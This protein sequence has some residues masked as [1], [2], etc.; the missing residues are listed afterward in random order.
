MWLGL[1]LVRPTL[2]LSRLRRADMSRWFCISILAA[3]LLSGTS[4]AT[5]QSGP[6]AKQLAA[7]GHTTFVQV[8]GGDEAKLGEAIQS[9]EQA[10][11]LNSSDTG[12]LY[13]LARA[14]FY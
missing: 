12:N 9:M 3:G 13:N 11:E 6:D 2:S 5:G 8:R 4:T 14:Y 1:C 7:K 10:L